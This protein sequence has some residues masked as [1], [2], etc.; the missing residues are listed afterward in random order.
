MEILICA[1]FLIIGLTIFIGLLKLLFAVFAI[2]TVIGII[3]ASSI[4]LI[5]WGPGILIGVLLVIILIG[6]FR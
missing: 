1:L 3:I 4:I 2:A 6:L 5:L